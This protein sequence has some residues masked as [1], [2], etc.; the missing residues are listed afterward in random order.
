MGIKKYKSYTPGRRFMTTSSFEE[1]TRTAKK[2]LETKKVGENSEDHLSK[3]GG[4]SASG[5]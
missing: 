2:S 5:S 3:R 1:I 4:T